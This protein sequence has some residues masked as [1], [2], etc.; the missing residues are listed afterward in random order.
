[1]LNADDLHAGALV[2]DAHND[3]LD[4]RREKGD[5]LDLAPADARYQA[6]LPRL[7][8]GGVNA[9]FA[10]CGLTELPAALRLTEATIRMT[11]AHP[12]DFALALT[13]SQVRAAV[14]QGKVAV[15]LQIESFTCCLGHLENVGAFHRLGVRV[16]NLTHGE[17]PEHSCQGDPSPWNYWTEAERARMRHDLRGLTDF[18]VACVRELNRLG[19]VVDLA[20]CND[21]AFFEAL[22]LSETTPVFSHGGVFALCPHARGLTDD[23]IRALAQRGGVHGVACYADFIHQ[24]PGRADVPALVNQI[25][26]SIELVGPDHVGIG[27]DFDGLGDDGVAVPNDVAGLPEVTREMVRRGWEDDAIRQVLGGNFVRV[28][29]TVLG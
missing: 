25:E 16:G 14:A 6:D 1:M 27:A 28:L 3:S 2:L 17:A 10:Q 24:E 15:V 29:E 21:A 13:G 5:P 8:Q 12:E 20:H 9:I 19:A 4:R 22:E 18:G 7:R 23:Q 26:H 11:E